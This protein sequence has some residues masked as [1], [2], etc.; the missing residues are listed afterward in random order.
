MMYRPMYNPLTGENALN[1]RF[2]AR[3]EPLLRWYRVQLVFSGNCKN[4]ERTYPLYNKI[5]TNWSRGTTSDPYI[6]RAFDPSD[7][8]NNTS[9]PI[10]L[11]LGI[12]GRRGDRCDTHEWTVG[13]T[14]KVYGFGLLEITR[15]KLY[16]E[17]VD[18]A[19]RFVDSFMMCSK[20]GCVEA[21]DVPKLT[22]RELQSKK[23]SEFSDTSNKS[24]AMTPPTQDE[25]TVKNLTRAYQTLTERALAAS[26]DSNWHSEISNV[27]M[28]NYWVLILVA[29]ALLSVVVFIIVACSVCFGTFGNSSSST[30]KSDRRRGNYDENPEEGDSGNSRDLLLLENAPSSA[31]PSTS[32]RVSGRGKWTSDDIDASQLE[33][34]SAGCNVVSHALTVLDL[35]STPVSI[36]VSPLP[37]PAPQRSRGMYSLGVT[38]GEIASSNK[39][40]SRGV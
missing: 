16:F 3:V 20:P 8:T 11:T 14:K 29:V 9:S 28:D 33:M 23:P 37:T 18:V 25:G 26:H 17:V 31:M 35:E 39:R 38:H 21:P 1:P 13:E 36:N 6:T 34:L 32:R 30:N 27:L 24:P 5:V 2:V 10:Y 22:E 40:P 12:G 7:G 19:D 4:Y 15:T